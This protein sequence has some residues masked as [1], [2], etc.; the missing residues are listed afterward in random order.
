MDR[1][2]SP[3]IP[4][5]CGWTVR[6]RSGRRRFSTLQN[7]SEDQSRSNCSTPSEAACY[8]GLPSSRFEPGGARRRMVQA[9]GSWQCCVLEAR[10]FERD[11][12]LHEAQVDDVNFQKEV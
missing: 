4:S 2:K 10:L 9:K 7:R 11:S 8:L 5:A 3:C 1:S 6:S 12:S